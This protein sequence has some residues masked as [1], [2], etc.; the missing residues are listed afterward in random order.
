MTD[1]LSWNI[2]NGRGLDGEVSLTRIADVIA[3]MGEPD[4]IC[5]QEVSR[6]L[7]LTPK[8]GA[9]DQVAELADLFPAHEIVFGV[10]VDAGSP[11]AQNRWQFGNALLSRL[12][13]LSL[14][15]HPLPRPGAGGMRHMTRQATEVVVAT[16]AGEL[17]IVNLHLEY[18]SPAQRLA[19]VERLRALQLEAL[20]QRRQPSEVDSDGPYQFVPRPVESVYCGDFNMV[21]GSREHRRLGDPLE[22]EPQPF[23]D[24]WELAHPHIPHAPTCGVFDRVQWPEGPHCRDFFFVNGRCVDAVKNLRVD[25]ETDASDHQ[26]LLLELADDPG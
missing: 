16:A 24:A 15:S 4:V 13:L 17:R 21:I 9:P 11:V 12:P 8:A 18:H 22:G 20:E 2:Q 6:G 5:L 23:R 10:A 26:P 7:W 25:T 1:I 3:T 19:Q 14:Q